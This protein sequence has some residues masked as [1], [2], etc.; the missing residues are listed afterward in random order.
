V[1]QNSIVRPFL[2]GIVFGTEKDEAELSDVEVTGNS[3]RDPCRHGIA[4]VHGVT[5]DAPARTTIRRARIAG[6]TIEKSRGTSSAGR[7]ILVGGLESGSPG[8]IC[9]EISV[10]GNLVKME[11][12][13]DAEDPGI[14]FD[15]RHVAIVEGSPFLRCAVRDNTVVGCN[16]GWG[17]D[18]AYL[19]YSVVSGNGIYAALHGLRLGGIRLKAVT[20]PLANHVHGNRVDASGTVY[21]L[22]QSRGQNVVR[23]N[24]NLRDALWVWDGDG[25]DRFLNP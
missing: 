1:S 24:V 5:G 15:P 23:G 7:G 4:C 6:N 25:D 12:D 9:E 3:I 18:L 21:E 16:A 22:D 19:G 17:I 20:G 14:S 11:N 2:D 13:P 8:Q 10:D